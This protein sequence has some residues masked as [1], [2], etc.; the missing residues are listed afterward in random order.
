MKASIILLP[1]LCTAFISCSGPADELQ[2]SDPE[3]FEVIL[4]KWYPSETISKGVIYPYAGHEECGKDFLEFN[5]EG[6]VE[7]IKILN[8]RELTDNS[9]S[10]N[11]TG[12]LLSIQ[13]NENEQIQFEIAKMDGTSMELI[14]VDQMDGDGVAEERRTY[15][16]E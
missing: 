13:Y 14:F 1:I 9:G 5:R 11:V 6:I 15:L 12:Y 2:F 3:Y 7:S 10:F 16:R 4:G 8:C